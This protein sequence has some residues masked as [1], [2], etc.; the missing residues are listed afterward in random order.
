MGEDE[1][2]GEA[3][4]QVEEEVAALLDLQSDGAVA[5]F[6]RRV[7]SGVGGGGGR[8]ERGEGVFQG[9]SAGADDDGARFVRLDHL[10]TFTP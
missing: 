10:E 9:L 5:G 3:A 1:G 2:G 6:D 7:E 4:G 8:G